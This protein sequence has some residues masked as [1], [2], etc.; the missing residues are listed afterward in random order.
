MLLDNRNIIVTGGA[1]GIGRACCVGAAKEGANVAVADI[2]RAGAEQTAAMVR[3]AGGQAIVVEMDTRK[4]AEAQ[5]MAHETL[6]AFG[7]IDG[8]ICGALKL[9]PSKLE[10][11]S[12]EAWDTLMDVGLKGY[13]FCAQAAGRHML[14]RGTGSIV[15]ISSV[16]AVQAYPLA[17]AY[18]VA[19]A[20]AVMLAKLIGVEWGKRGVRGNAVIA[21]QCHT[22]MTDAMFQD[23]EI[24]AGRAA[25]VPMNRVALPHEI[26]D[27]C[28][29][30]LSDRASYINASA[31]TVDG[32]Q[33][34]SKMMHTPG[35]NWGGKKLEY[36]T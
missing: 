9:S 4:A 18:S 6:D 24:A 30:L 5:R 14:E 19:K 31:V 17:G 2:N 26:A 21:G 13:F 20:G 29:F 33:V 10:D 12:E 22:P 25:V 16:A 23:P 35:R 36:K 34:E 3:E 11:L 7:T 15:L 8:I 32:G 27:A 1:S 28:L